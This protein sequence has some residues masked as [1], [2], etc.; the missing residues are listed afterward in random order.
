MTISAHAGDI[1]R[2]LLI[3]RS[4]TG[5]KAFTLPDSDVP[6]QNLPDS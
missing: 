6:E 5:R 3:D 2:R 1:D 4:V